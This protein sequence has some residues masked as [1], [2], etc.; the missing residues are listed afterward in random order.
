M[1]HSSE[2]VFERD[3]HCTVYSVELINADDW[4]QAFTEPDTA[5]DVRVVRLASDDSLDDLPPWISVEPAERPAGIADRTGRQEVGTRANASRWQSSPSYRDP[6]SGLDDF[7]AAGIEAVCYPLQAP[8]NERRHLDM[9][10]TF[11]A[12]CD[13]PLR[14]FGALEGDQAERWLRVTFDD[15]DSFSEALAIE[16]IRLDGAIEVSEALRFVA[17]APV[18]DLPAYL[19]LA[20]DRRVLREQASPWRYLAGEPFA[21]ALSAV[22][23]WRRRYQ[24][25]YTAHY[26]TVAQEVVLLLDALDRSL[27]ACGALQQLNGITTLGRPVGIASVAAHGRA[28]QA[29]DTIP[30]EANVDAPRTAD[31]PLGRDPLAFVAARAA[32]EAVDAALE[33]QRRRLAARAMHFVLDRET[34]PALDRLLQAITASDVSGIERA[35]DDRL[36]A[37]IDLTLSAAAASPLVEF[38]ERFPVVTEATVDQVVG[39]FRALLDVAIR[40]SANGQAVL[41]EDRPAAVA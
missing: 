26:R 36:A 24:I 14:H 31:V 39:E 41:R 19:E 11:T 35:L 22:Q 17:R 13:T 33:T 9:L 32:I 8:T 4:D 28:R 5:I 2:T 34:V 21:G 1:A 27:A 18:P 3:H 15:P 6:G 25:A 29:L 30:S 10:R 38:A 40:A 12:N 23:A 16:R 37:H 20:I 7:I